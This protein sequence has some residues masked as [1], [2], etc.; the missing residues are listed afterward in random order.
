MTTEDIS[1]DEFRTALKSLL[2]TKS[3]GIDEISVNVVKKVSTIIEP[4]LYHIFNIS[5]V[6]GKFPDALKIAEVTPIFKSGDTCDVGN[7]R[8]ISVLPCFSRILER[9]M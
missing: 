4:I 3:P 2:S 5:L 1:L 8:P 7:Y 9:I 6:S